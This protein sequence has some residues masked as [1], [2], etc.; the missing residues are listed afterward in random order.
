MDIQEKRVVLDFMK[1]ST[2]SMIGPLV[3]RNKVAKHLRP[4]Q[5]NPFVL[6]RDQIL[7]RAVHL[8]NSIPFFVEE[9]G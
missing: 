3:I 1:D 9:I 7:K 6:L 4:G 5:P 2:R 8:S